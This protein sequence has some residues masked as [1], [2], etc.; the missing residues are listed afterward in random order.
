MTAVAS[1]RF[2]EF[3]EAVRGHEPFLW[4]ADLVGFPET[5]DPEITHL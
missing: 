1:D 5:F 4:Q 2:P 3:F